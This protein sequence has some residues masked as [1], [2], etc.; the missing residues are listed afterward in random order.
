MSG[1]GQSPPEE[2]QAERLARVE[3]RLARVEEYLQLGTGAAE[4]APAPGDE[5]QRGDELEFAVG[6]RWFANVGILVLVIGTLFTLS[7][8]YAGLPAAVPPLMGYAVAAAFLVLARF[9]RSSFE[10]ISG[11]LRG[12]GMALLYFATLRL[13]HFGG[14]H[15]LEASS[16]A[17]AGLLVL[18]AGTNLALG[19]RWKSPWLTGLALAT[20]YATA[21]AVGTPWFVL[22]LTASLA[23]ASVAAARL[24]GWRLLPL[25]G[26]G[27]TYATLLAWIIGDPLLGRPLALITGPS[28]TLAF[29]LGCAVILAAG[30]RAAGSGGTEDAL[31]NIGTLFNC[32][33]AFS[34][35]VLCSLFCFGQSFVAANLAASVVFIAL[36]LVFWVREQSRVATFL[37]AMTGYLALSLAII[38][39]ADVPQVFIWLS[40]QSLLVVA[41]AIWFKSRFIVVANFLIYAAIVV[42]YMALAR[43]ETGI[44]LAFAV[45]AI[46]TARLLNWRNDRLEL[47]T[48]LMVNAYLVSALVVFPYALYHLVPGSYVGLA[49]VG[50]A[51]LYYGMNLVARSPKYRWMGHATL[52]FTAAYLVVVGISRLEPLYRNLSFLVLGTVLLIVSVIFTRLRARLK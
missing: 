25:L 2:T 21:L 7:L 9:A 31:D 13:C 22:V 12:A 38:K 36:S 30:P 16:A 10:V 6:Q 43:V 5:R 49:W 51:L 14:R 8:P 34:L 15:L 27:F 32:G 46:G 39:A 40:L 18:A 33:G 28:A 3:A 50:A 48:G 20:G 23:G 45:V 11:N 42:A 52:L 17:G 4:A 47:K 37:Y 35:F 44:S 19:L 24:R 26:I 41:T 29:L 1:S